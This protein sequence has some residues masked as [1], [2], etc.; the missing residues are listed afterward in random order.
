[1][2]KKNRFFLNFHNI[3]NVNGGGVGGQRKPNLVN[4]VCERSLGAFP[5]PF[6]A[7]ALYVLQIWVEILSG[8]VL[9][10]PKCVFT[11]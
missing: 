10:I 5:N 9:Y 6:P 1:M 7:G 3:E 2:V 11:R 4:V 8:V